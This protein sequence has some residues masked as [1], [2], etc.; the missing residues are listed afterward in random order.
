[1]TMWMSMTLWCNKLILFDVIIRALCDDVHLC[2]RCVREFWSCHVHSSHSVCLLKPGVTEEGNP[3]NKSANEHKNSLSQVTKWWSW[4]LELGEDFDLLNVYW[5]EVF[6]SCIECWI[7]NTW[8]ALNEVVG[9]IYSPQSLPSHWQSLLA[10]GARDSP[11][12]HRT[13]TVHCPVRA[14][15][16]RPLGFGIVDRWSPLSFCCTGQSGDLWILLSDLC[17]GTVHLCSSEQLTVGAQTAIA[18]L[19][20]GQS[21]GTP[22]GP[23]NYSGVLPEETREWLVRWLPGLVHRTVSGAH[24]TVSSAPLDST[25]SILLQFLIVF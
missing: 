9:G 3:S 8:M 25:L 11:V 6:C 4:F 10:M 22:D 24:W 20:H 13:V 17:R 15:S 1:M 2:N 7:Q 21:G 14:T 18:P 19:A 16:A 23:K 12:S 5:S